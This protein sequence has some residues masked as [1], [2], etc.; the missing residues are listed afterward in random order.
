MELSFIKNEISEEFLNSLE[1]HVTEDDI[2]NELKKTPLTLR[3]RVAKLEKGYK[4]IDGEIPVEDTRYY[5]PSRN[6]FIEAAE[7]VYIYIIQYHLRKNWRTVKDSKEPLISNI[8]NIKPKYKQRELLLSQDESELILSIYQGHLDK[9]IETERLITLLCN[10]KR[11]L[12][13]ENKKVSKAMSDEYISFF[14]NTSNAPLDRSLSIAYN[15]IS[16]FAGGQNSHYTEIR[17]E[18]KKIAIKYTGQKEISIENAIK[19]GN[20]LTKEIE[21]LSLGKI[22]DIS[23]R[24]SS[25][26]KEEDKK[27]KKIKRPYKKRGEP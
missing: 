24:N 11:L 4:R 13:K 8:K 18:L 12:N 6:V 3:D 14:K 23:K 17:N 9:V 15:S 1:I 27:R 20:K 16:S 26:T 10:P 5:P 7:S 22:P 19:R 2:F 25:Q 21:Q